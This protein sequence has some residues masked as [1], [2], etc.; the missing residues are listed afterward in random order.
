MNQKKEKHL[1]PTCGS[2]T[3]AYVFRFDILD[4]RLLKAMGA[5]VNRRK[6]AENMPF[7]EANKVHVPSMADLSLAIRCRTTQCSKLGLVAKAKK[8]EK[9]IPGT[10]IVTAR[11][12]KALRGEDVPA[13]VEVFRKQITERPD[14]LTNA[15]KIALAAGYR[16]ETA[17]WVEF[18]DKT[19]TIVNGEVL[20]K[21]YE[22][23]SLFP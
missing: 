14:D 2:V 3:S 12:W 10:W 8:G 17:E 9:H 7:T 16:Y 5:E 11:G 19:F 23:G 13:T 1:C 21:A 22:K 4:L 18:S 6:W 15:T 20:E